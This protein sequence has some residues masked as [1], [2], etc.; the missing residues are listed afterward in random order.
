MSRPGTGGP[1]PDL[2]LSE[3][4]RMATCRC[5]R[6]RSFPAHDAATRRA[7]P[8]FQHREGDVVVKSVVETGPLPLA[9]LLAIT[10][11]V[12][13]AGAAPV[14]AAGAGT[15]TITPLSN[16]ADLISAGDAVLRVR[17]PRDARSSAVRVQA[18]SSDVTS[19]FVRESATSLLGTLDGLPLGRSTIT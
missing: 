5:M 4:D 8:R 2:S 12:L 9:V 10:G 3:A 7:P 19:R 13:L 1:S 16:R 14:R 18:G 6:Q 11:T 17:V 15:V